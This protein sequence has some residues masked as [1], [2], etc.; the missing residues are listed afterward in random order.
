MVNSGTT[1]ETEIVKK[2]VRINT[3]LNDAIRNCKKK[4]TNAALNDAIGSSYY[5]ILSLATQT[6]SISTNPMSKVSFH[7][8]IWQCDVLLVQS[9][10][11]TKGCTYDIHISLQKILTDSTS[12]DHNDKQ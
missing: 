9:G 5:E 3:A 2:Y 12:E 6:I 1:M 8:G 4:C 7:T 11:K 10:F